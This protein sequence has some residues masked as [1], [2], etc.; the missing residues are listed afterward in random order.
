MN[1][2]VQGTAWH[3]G[4]P[5]ARARAEYSFVSPPRGNA[6]TLVQPGL[7][8]IDV[9]S[10]WRT[11]G[12]ALGT[13]RASVDG[14]RLGF[15]AHPRTRT[16]SP[17]ISAHLRPRD[18]GPRR[19]LIGSCYRSAETENRRDSRLRVGFP[20]SGRASMPI[21][22]TRRAKEKDAFREPRRGT[23]SRMCHRT[24]PDKCHTAKQQ[25]YSGEDSR[26]QDKR[27]EL[28]M[29]IEIPSERGK[30]VEFFQNSGRRS[31]CSDVSLLDTN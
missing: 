24:A 30:P 12:A 21:L 7:R 28:E 17:E 9:I 10:T 20:V 11:P 16:P 29:T 22:L 5:A 1:A 26:T 31:A 27:H 2:V 8:R 4:C 3:T 23:P 25:E 13:S 6:R 15:N 18:C 19:W 14:F